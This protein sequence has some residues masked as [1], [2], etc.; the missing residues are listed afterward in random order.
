MTQSAT[1][2]WHR[3]DLRLSDNPALHYAVEQGAVQPVFIYDETKSPWVYGGASKW[4]LHH[5]LAAL[6]A[7]YKKLGVTLLLLRGSADA[8]IPQTAK[9][10]QATQI[11]WNRRYEP[12]GIAEDK[13]LKATLQ[14]LNFAVHSF[15]SHLLMEPWAIQTKS[16]T[17]FK[18]FTPFWRALSAASPQ[19]DAIIERPDAVTAPKHA[20][21]SDHLSDWNLLP[22]KPNWAKSFEP[23][24]QIGEAAAQKTMADFLD[25][26][27]GHYKTERDFPAI[28]ATSQLSPHLAFGEISPRQIW[29]ATQTAQQQHKVGTAFRTDSEA[30]LRQIGWRDFAYHL[31]YHYPH[32]VTEPLYP[33]YKEFP[34][35]TDT[36]GFTAWTKGQTGYPLVDAGMRQMWQTGWM[37]N[38]V[39]LITASFLIKDLGIAWQDGSQWFWDTLVDADLANNSMGW[40]WVAGCGADASPYYRIFNPTLQSAKFDPKG[41]YIRRFVPE[42]AALPDKYIHSP[43][44]APTEVLKAAGIVLGKTYPKP[45]VDHSMARDRALG[46]LKEF[47]A[48]KAS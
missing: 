19:I 8:V 21:K 40:Q 24:W 10:L 45:I 47:K 4:W 35:L 44:D 48:K 13:T 11:V 15:N 31:L 9:A 12:H 23:E 46:L 18:V 14:E 42:L 16:K 6:Q 30:F 33:Q 29:Y 41:D 36:D 27:A 3:H 34:W 25:D 37:H 5:S 1:L 7:D 28:D 26:K 17:P 20:I 22:T 32:T 38:R 39:R 2:Y 43:W